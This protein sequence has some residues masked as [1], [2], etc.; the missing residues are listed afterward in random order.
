M[1]KII[2]KIL[3]HD[4]IIN[5]IKVNIYYS[6]GRSYYRNKMWK[7]SSNTINKNVKVIIMFLF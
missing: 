7:N 1:I 4:I 5:E 6:F 3:L 2:Y